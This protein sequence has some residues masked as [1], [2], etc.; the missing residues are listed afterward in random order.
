M[1]RERIFIHD[2]SG[3]LV[4]DPDG[5]IKYATNLNVE[6]MWPGGYGRGSFVVKRDIVGRW[7]VK[8]AYEVIVRDGQTIIYQGKIGDLER[9]LSSNDQQIMVPTLGFN[10]VL[11]E[12]EMH[13]RWADTAMTDRTELAVGLVGSSASIQ[14]RFI[15]VRRAK[16]LN[17]KMVSDD[18]DLLNTDRY[19]EFYDMPSGETVKRVTFAY[20]IVTGEGIF[21][22][23]YNGVP[24]LGVSVASTTTSGTV[25]HTF[26]TPTQRI[27]LQIGPF[28][29]DIYD[30]NDI[31]TITS[32]TAY[33]E[34]GTIDAKAIFE[35]V[36]AAIGTEI[37]TD[38]DAIGNPGLAI[39]PFITMG[40]GPESGDSIIRRA[41]NYGDTSFRTW[42]HAIWDETG[43]TDGKPKAHLDY[44]DISDY[45]FGAHLK[46]LK[47]FTDTETDD[48]LHN[49]IRVE[50]QDENN[51]TRYR[52]P[53]ENAN[54]Q[55]VTS[56]AAYGR[57]DHLITIGA[58]DATEA[59]NEGRRY[60]ALHEDPLR[61]ASW[62]ISGKAR[63]K[64][65]GFVPVSHIR[66]GKPFKIFDYENGKIFWLRRT[67]YDAEKG[68]LRCE[69]DLPPDDL[70]IRMAQKEL[71]S[72]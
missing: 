46:D 14:E 54:L 16:Y 67:Q 15:V 59:D 6:T 68:E 10:S 71:R 40:N 57:R 3:V 48:E 38:Y 8:M 50:Y 69:P 39:V 47:D 5:S 65:G 30:G 52:T 12:R 56:V 27:F 13:K 43:T 4:N 11:I 34:T 23:L 32:L 64:G 72:A 31:I 53:N 58:G 33:S 60:L 17:I 35:D 45:V 42:G 26:A 41:A 9:S 20:N 24:T 2:R 1:P 25:D 44:R 66:A 55:D 61:K 51:I 22:G 7:A 29:S 28:T 19:A 70:A 49:Y 62:K 37:S 21:V 18:T 36:L 63:R